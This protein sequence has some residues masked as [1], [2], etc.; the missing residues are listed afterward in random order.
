MANIAET[1]GIEPQTPVVVTT[2][3]TPATAEPTGDAASRVNEL[4]EQLANM[5]EEKLRLEGR[6]SQLEQWLQTGPERRGETQADRKV[7]E[8]AQ[9]AAADEFRGNTANWMTQLV[10]EDGWEAQ[11]TPERY[12]EIAG[13]MIDSP[14]K[15]LAEWTNDVVR[16]VKAGLRESLTRYHVA[17]APQMY[18]WVG[19]IVNRAL[20]QN[21][22]VTDE[23]SGVVA[24]WDDFYQ[25]RFPALGAHFQG[26]EAE[27]QGDFTAV[28]QSVADQIAREMAGADFDRETLVRTL[29]RDGFE[30][31]L[32]NYFTA[33][34][35]RL[36][37]IWHVA[38]TPAQPAVAPAQPKAAGN[39]K[40][41]GGA[42]PTARPGSPKT[43]AE[44]LAEAEMDDDPIA[45]MLKAKEQFG[46]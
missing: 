14:E 16:V 11:F 7:L 28:A 19:K 36:Q 37:R 12:A 6:T 3:E 1:P 42:T 23:R 45:S 40:G 9:K 38:A 21:R 26:L 34:G 32:D 30:Q 22:N 44:R 10:P 46:I 15:A 24:Q 35:G 33:V 20:D 41:A 17:N 43:V 8:D 5:T 2:V 31:D 25:R 29:L 27:A 39:P 18:Q 13:Q 4:E